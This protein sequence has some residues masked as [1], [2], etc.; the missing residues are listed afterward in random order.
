MVAPYPVVGIASATSVRRRD[1]DMWALASRRFRQYLLLA[2]GIPVAAAVLERIGEELEARRGESQVSR[3]LRS[4]GSWLHQRAT[5]PL[6]RR[7]R[8]ARAEGERLR[9]EAE[10]QD[11]WS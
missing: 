2:I 11:R 3:G 10:E 1:S 8:A 6:A 7:M 9:E 4:S 5:G